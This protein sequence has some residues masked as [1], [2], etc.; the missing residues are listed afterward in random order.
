MKIIERILWITGL[1]LLAV[2]LF[3]WARG[4]YFSR[5]D[6]ARFEQARAAEEARL[7]LDLAQLNYQGKLDQL[8]GDVEKAELEE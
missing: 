2:A 7:E 3:G 8:T 1:L 4:A 5:R 6:V